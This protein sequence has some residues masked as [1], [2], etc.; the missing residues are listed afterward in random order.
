MIPT[1][2]KERIQGRGFYTSAVFFPTVARG[3]AA[4]RIC[5]TAY[6]TRQEIEGLCAAVEIIRQEIRDL[7]P[8]GRR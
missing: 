3:E 8:D 5:L 2:P 7:Y 4:L 1:V 6:H